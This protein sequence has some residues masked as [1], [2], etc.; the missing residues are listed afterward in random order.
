MAVGAF[1]SPFNI[2]DSEIAF[3]HTYLLPE[4]LTARKLCVLSY[5]HG[6]NI[7]MKGENIE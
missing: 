6:I 4:Y 2:H 5:I 1:C 3:N 7:L